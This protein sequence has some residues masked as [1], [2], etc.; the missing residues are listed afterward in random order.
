MKILRL[1]GDGGGELG[2][3]DLLFHRPLG[4]DFDE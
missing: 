4:L 1:D 3:G 2:E